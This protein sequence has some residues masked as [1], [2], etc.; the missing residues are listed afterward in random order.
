MK[1]HGQDAFGDFTIQPG[2]CGVCDFNCS[3]T[4][5]YK[6][7]KNFGLPKGIQ[8]EKT[9]LKMQCRKVGLDCGCY[10]KLHRQIAHIEDNMRVKA[11]APAERHRD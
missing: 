4:V 2:W 3:T 11:N 7:N 1:E 5:Q 8:I 6:V 9:I 10:G